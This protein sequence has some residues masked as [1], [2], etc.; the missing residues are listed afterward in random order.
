MKKN[1]KNKQI[2]NVMI[3]REQVKQ[4]KASFGVVQEEQQ[5][6]DKCVKSINFRLTYADIEDTC[7]SNRST[8]FDE[9]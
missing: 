3:A 7:F 6:K 9:I 8:F 5:K 1:E 4:R 2:T